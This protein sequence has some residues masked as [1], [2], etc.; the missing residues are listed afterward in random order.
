MKTYFEQMIEAVETIDQEQLSLLANQIKKVQLDGGRLILCG[1]GGSATTAEHAS[2][3][4]SKGLSMKNNRPFRTLCLNSNVAQMTAW[5]NDVAYEDA[6][7]RMLELE[8]RSQDA[9][10]V[11]SGS[12]NSGNILNA[13]KYAVEQDVFTCALTGFDGGDVGPLSTLH[14]NTQS[15][16]MQIIENIH[17]VIIHY[18]LKAVD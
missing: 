16:D 12:G 1:N 7:M 11:I 14:I 18:L 8:L 9:L 6:F 5:S 4:L 3:D 2:V 17:L 10:L 15:Q 13:V